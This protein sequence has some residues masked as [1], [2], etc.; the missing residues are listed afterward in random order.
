MQEVLDVK[1]FQSFDIPPKIILVQRVELQV[2]AVVEE[3]F[4]TRCVEGK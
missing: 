3:I 2:D 1:R 4:V